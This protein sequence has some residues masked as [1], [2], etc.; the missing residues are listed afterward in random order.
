[1]HKPKKIAKWVLTKPTDWKYYPCNFSESFI[2]RSFKNTYTN[3]PSKHSQDT[4]K[5]V[6]CL[7]QPRQGSKYLFLIDSQY[8]LKYKQ[9]YELGKNQINITDTNI[10][11]ARSIFISESSYKEITL[12][13]VDFICTH[14]W[15]SASFLLSSFLP[16]S[17]HRFMYGL[18]R[19]LEGWSS[20]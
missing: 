13:K 10:Y 20:A 9:V 7:L 5:G 17:R 8:L 2:E 6:K 3:F 15:Y 14:V 12:L 19:I 18:L 4:T 11:D 16:L 1:M